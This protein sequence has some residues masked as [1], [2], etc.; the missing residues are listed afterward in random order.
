VAVT[1]RK[2]SSNVPGGEAADFV[3]DVSRRGVVQFG[4][5]RRSED[6]IES[7]EEVEL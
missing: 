4:I 1:F 5:G 2:R 6:R 3:K 7:L